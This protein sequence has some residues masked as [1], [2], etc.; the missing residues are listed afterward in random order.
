MRAMTRRG[1]WSRM[2][3]RALRRPARRSETSVEPWRLREWAIGIYAGPQ[4]WALASAPGAANPVLTAHDVTDA[5]AVFVADPFMIPGPGGWQMFFEVMNESHGKGEIGLAVSADGLRWQYR[6]IVLREPFHL[7]YPLVF[8]WR[9]AYCMVPESGATG[10]VRLYRA[11][12]FPTEWVC[13]ATLLAGGRWADATLLW[14][15]ERWWL[16]AETD[17][18]FR[19]DTLRL[20]SAE[21]VEGSW[22]EHPASPV[23]S[24]D[25]GAARPAGRVIVHNGQIIRYAQDCRPV[26]GS[27]VR[28][29]AVT[30]LTPTRYSEVEIAQSP[31]LSK[32][33]DTWNADGMH[34]IDAHQVAGGGWFACVDGW[35]W[36]SFHR[37]SM[38]VAPDLVASRPWRA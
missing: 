24:G 27:S 32:G 36:K 37:Q 26:Y 19:H 12:V 34:H 1:F 28:A 21:H 25:P 31:V 16:F 22:S 11:S 23:V 2:I 38:G 8:K 17:P 6:Q 33:P 10:S 18:Q 3:R 5:P 15:E 13:I 4:P 7:S 30:E 29:F 20:Y 35:A 14:H 9:D